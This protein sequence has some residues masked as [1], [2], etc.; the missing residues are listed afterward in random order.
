M[1][2]LVFG[3]GNAFAA[4][5]NTDGLVVKIEPA[6]PFVSLFMA[7]PVSPDWAYT[8]TEF[9]A[10]PLFNLTGKGVRVGIIDSGISPHNDIPKENIVAEKSFIEGEEDITEDHTN[11]GTSVAALIVGSNEAGVGAKGFAPEA[12]IVNA[13]IINSD[14]LVEL[15]EIANAIDYCVEQGC[16]VINMSFGTSNT[17]IEDYTTFPTL[18]DWHNAIQRAISAGCIVIAAAGNYADERDERDFLVYPAALPD[19]IAVGGTKEGYLHNENSQ[20]NESVFVSAPGKYIFTATAISE[21]SCHYVSGTSF[22]API[23][24][25]L[26][27]LIKEAY[28]DATQNQVKAILKA[29]AIDIGDAGY[30]YKFGNGYVNG[31]NLAKYL[32]NSDFYAYFNENGQ[33]VCANLGDEKNISGYTAVYSGGR[34]TSV[35]ETPFLLA[36]MQKKTI[37][38]PESGTVKQFFWYQGVALNPVCSHLVRQ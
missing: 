7:Q 35:T 33:A 15:S 32:R 17:G 38:L 30:D 20:K 3:T 24:S 27:A 1:L 9:E 18:V 31:K 14:G 4:S 25:G 26:A 22:A 28:P 10:L 16:D 19:V 2:C 37:D 21:S 12:E 23:V 6:V 11:H 29:I 34:N 13:R 5:E 36:G 8:E